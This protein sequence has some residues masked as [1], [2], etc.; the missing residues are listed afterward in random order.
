MVFVI[1]ARWKELTS[2]EDVGQCLSLQGSIQMTAEQ[3]DRLFE[4]LESSEETTDE[5]VQ[6]LIEIPNSEE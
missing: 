3:I 5:F 4:L 6:I 1:L 2:R